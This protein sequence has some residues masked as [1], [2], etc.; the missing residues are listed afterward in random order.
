VPGLILAALTQLLR[1][2]DVHDDHR[3]LA[4]QHQGEVTSVRCPSCAAGWFDEDNRH[5]LHRAPKIAQGLNFV[6][7]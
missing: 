5:R 7:R 2:A 4:F 1:L 6:F 3:A